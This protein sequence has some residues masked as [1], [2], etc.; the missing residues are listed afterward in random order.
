MKPGH[1]YGE[2]AM[3]DGTAVTL[4]APRKSD[5]DQFLKFAN[6]IVRERRTNRELGITSLDRRVKRADE[7]KFLDRVMT[8]VRTGNV[9]S[10]CAFDDGR[11]VGSC[12]VTR[13][14]S[15]DERHS[16]VLGIVILDGYRGKGLGQAMVS[17]ALE[18]A[19][20][21]GVWLVE[22]AVFVTNARARHVYEKH[23]FKTVGFV[24]YKILRDGRFTGEV[25][26]YVDLRRRGASA[27]TRV[28][29]S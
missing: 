7:K 10:V 18:E 19:R 27:A 4:R 15:R 24:P 11:V 26:M 23:G 16:G 14:K 9:V 25:N 8:G 2:H 20:R 29:H 12:D 6:A 21:L 1:V 13:R 3:G 5:L 17:V 22:L 28:P